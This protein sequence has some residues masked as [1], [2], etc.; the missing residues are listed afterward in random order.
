MPTRSAAR[1][2]IN[3]K[4]VGSWVAAAQLGADADAMLVVTEGDAT[5]RL[6]EGRA[7]AVASFSGWGSEIASLTSLCGSGWQLL[8]TG[9]GDWTETDE[10]HA[11]EIQNHLARSVSPPVEFPG[12]VVLLLTP[13]SSTDA[14][15]P[16]KS[17]V[18]GIVRNL[19]TGMYET[20]RL[21][22]ACGS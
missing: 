1:E 8:V 3:S 5:A 6:Y 20:Y 22:M 9:N 7:D 15:A 18:I 19:Q 13:G 17:S 10:I 21:T 16:V 2:L 4:K 14:S 11:V 12:P